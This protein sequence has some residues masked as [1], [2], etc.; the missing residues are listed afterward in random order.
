M[1]YRRLGKTELEV[2]VVGLGTWQYGG[3]WAVDY[4]QEEVNDVFAAAR[5]KGINF[6]DTAECYGDHLS[7]KFIGNAIKKDRDYWIVA[8]KFGHFYK[9][10]MDRD[11]LWT[12]NDVEKQLEDSLKA[13]QI[14]CIDLYQFHSG[15]DE[16]FDNDELWTWLDKQK[17]A[18]KIKHLGVSVSGKN[19]PHQIENIAKVGASTLQIV[20]NRIANKPENEVWPACKK[21]DIGILA[22]VPL[23]SGYLTGKYLPGHDFG[24][25]EFRSTQ[26]QE[27][28]EACLKLAQEIKANEV[29]EGVDMASWAL[30]WCLRDE[31]VTTVIPGCKNSDQVEKNAAAV[32]LIEIF[33]SA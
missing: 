17:A 3:E 31:I 24:T 16:E 33:A 9:G 21:N 2:S 6:I 28:R 12:K 7:E 13:L 20:Y 1:I 22:R 5:D 10:L 18:G 32:D 8:T 29:P 19:Q 23:A 25:K 27:Y 14:E 11:Q 4:K 26:D 15:T 30:A